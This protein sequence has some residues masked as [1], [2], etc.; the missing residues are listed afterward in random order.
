M[1]KKYTIY[2]GSSPKHTINMY[3]GLI[4]NSLISKKL[5]HKFVVIKQRL[6]MWFKKMLFLKQNG[7]LISRN[8]K[9]CVR[10]CQQGEIIAKFI[11]KITK[12]IDD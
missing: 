6:K 7:V 9:Y 11:R 12:K 5:S 1:N 8:R 4:F 2:I 3:F 10:I